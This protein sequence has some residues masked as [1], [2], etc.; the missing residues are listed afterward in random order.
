MSDTQAITYAAL[1]LHDSGANISGEKL[2]S[3]LAAAGIEVR[4][5]LPILYARYIQ[6]VGMSEIM[7]GACNAAA[8]PV[9]A[10]APAAAAAGAAPAAAAKPAA[11]AA[12]KPESDNEDDM[13][14]GLF[15]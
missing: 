4:P 8:A 5:T 1:M 9:A 2:S 14:M 10:G 6:K 11:K 15:D 12:A 13:G 3:V 7:A